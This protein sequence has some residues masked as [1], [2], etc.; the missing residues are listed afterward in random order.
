MRRSPSAYTIT[1][2][3]LSFS[4][5]PEASPCLWSKMASRPIFFDRASWIMQPTGF[6]MVF[7]ASDLH[8]MLDRLFRYTDWGKLRSCLCG[9]NIHRSG[10][11]I[12]FVASDGHKLLRIT[13]NDTENTLTHSI[14]IPN[15]TVTILRRIL[16][17]T[18]IVS[19]MYHTFDG[20]SGKKVRYTITSGNLTFYFTPTDDKYPNFNRVI[21]EA[22]PHTFR[23]DRMQLSRALDRMGMIAGNSKMRAYV[24]DGHISLHADDKDFAFEA[25]EKLPVE[26]SSK[27]FR[28]SFDADNVRKVLTSLRCKYVN[29]EAGELDRAILVMPDVQPEGEHITALFMPCFHNEDYDQ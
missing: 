15:R 23:I 7:Q 1:T 14:L 20:D 2:T 18:G 26:H 8:S 3:R 12:H 22:S 11:K 28:F 21:P 19:L 27:P 9:I 13:K 24:K 4:T 16:P 6:Y 17:H 25:I 5:L 10:G 29:F